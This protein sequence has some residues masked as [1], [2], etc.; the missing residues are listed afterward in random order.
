MIAATFLILLGG[1]L[2]F[3]LG[4]AI[5][6]ALFGVKHIDP[7][8]TQGS[9]GFRMLIIPGTMAFWPLLLRRWA[10]GVQEPPEE[11]NAHRLNAKCRV[12]NEK[13]N[14]SNPKVRNVLHSA[15]CIF[16]FL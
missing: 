15:I 8:A 3:G 9:W 13:H 12:K 1:Y 2:T 5:P 6:F 4:F 16:H 14:I 10:T 7:H 11:C